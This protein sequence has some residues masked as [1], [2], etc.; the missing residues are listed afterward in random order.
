MT[1]DED[2]GNREELGRLYGTK[3]KQKKQKLKRIMTENLAQA[4]LAS[5]LQQEELSDFLKEWRV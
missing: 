3:E 1:E 5:Q 4:R 2:R